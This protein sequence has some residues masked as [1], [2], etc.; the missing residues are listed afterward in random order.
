LSPTEHYHRTCR[1]ALLAFLAAGALVAVVFLIPGAG[2]RAH[3]VEWA[4]LLHDTGLPEG[5]SHFLLWA[6]GFVLMGGCAAATAWAFC[7]WVPVR[8]PK[9]GGAAY[10]RAEGSWAYRCRGCNHLHETGLGTE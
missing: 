9:C 5:V 6:A 2:G 4:T 3:L 7:R 1:Y 8:C 10:W